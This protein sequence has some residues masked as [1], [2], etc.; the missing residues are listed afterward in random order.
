MDR[1]VFFGVA[2]F[3]I[4]GLVNVPMTGSAEARELVAFPHGYEPGSV[5]VSTR[6]RLLYFVQGDGT[7]I[8]YRV[9]VG[10][11]G[12]QWFGTRIIDGKHI[13]PAWSPP[14]E[15]RRHKPDLPNVIPGGAPNNPMGAAALTIAPGE[16]A[17][18]GTSASM[19]SSIGRYASFGCIRMLDEDILD[20]LPRVR[21]P[22]RVHVVA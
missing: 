5:V 12:R 2:T 18:H 15:V 8:R 20:L 4:T 10:M 21:I 17:I 1:R 6:Q 7:A 13:R 14:A 9:A 22:S 16:Y 3:G 19:R 11:P